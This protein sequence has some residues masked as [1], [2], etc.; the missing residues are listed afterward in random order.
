MCG[1][2]RRC[3]IE[4]CRRRS[5]HGGTVQ[6]ARAA[7]VSQVWRRA[8]LL[9]PLG[10][11]NDCDASRGYNDDDDPDTRSIDNCD[12]NDKEHNDDDGCPSPRDPR[13]TEGPQLLMQCEY[14]WV[15]A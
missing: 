10:D 15:R 3:H 7:F 1:A 12:D 5:C 8:D 6:A 14:L 9:S 4:L 11:H 13:Y 2:V